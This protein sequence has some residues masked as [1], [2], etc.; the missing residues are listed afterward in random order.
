MAEKSEWP[1]YELFLRGLGKSPGGA[2][3]RVGADVATYEQVHHLALLWGGALLHTP[4]TPPAAVGVLA[5]KGTIAYAGIVAGLYAGATVV[6]LHPDF[7]IARTRQMIAAAGVS[8]L[9]VDERGRKVAA[10]LRGEGLEVSVLAP[11]AERVDPGHALSR[12]RPVEPGGV[13]YVLYTSGST[14]TPKGVPITHANLAHYF[15]FMDRRYDFTPRDVFSQTFDLTFDCAMFDLFCAW[16]AGATSVAVPSL[17]YRNLPRFLAEQGVTVWFSTPSA[18][19]MARRTGG[20]APDMMP[21]LRWSLFAGEAL[22]CADATDWQ[23]AAPRSVLEN[24]YGPTELT[25]T[26]TGHRWSERTSPGLCVNGLSP[27]GFVNDGHD[28]LLLDGQG[29]PASTEGELWITGPQTTPATSTLATTRAAS[30]S[31]TGASGTTPATGSG[32]SRT[33]NWSISAGPTPRSRCR[34]GASNWPRSTRP[35]AAAPASR[36]P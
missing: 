1:L 20:L 32:A 35:Y 30:S 19:S 25:I 4:A 21:F 18:I 27:I 22:K 13:A 2:A 10:E 29:Q 3:F 17:A 6:P 5:A 31:G 33:A 14:G 12:P 9:V 34:G 15:H 26:I 8:A 23:R 36:T 11:G 16:G 7:P 24:L 28:H